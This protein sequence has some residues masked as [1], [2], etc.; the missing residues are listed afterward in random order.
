[1]PTSDHIFI[2]YARDQGPGQSLAVRLQAR[3]EAHGIPCWR[4]E[5]DT[6]V[7][8][9]WPTHIPEA[10]KHARLM[11][12][13]VSTAAHDSHWVREEITLALRRD[14]AV[15]ILPVLAESD[16]ALP[17]GLNEF[18]PLDMATGGEEAFE[19]LLQRIGNLDS[20]GA[21]PARRVEI[22]YLQNLLH[23]Q[24]LEKLA[25]VYEPL[26]G[27]QRRQATMA[28]VL[29]GDEMQ[30]DLRLLRQLFAAP[31]KEMQAPEHFE[32]VLVVLGKASRLAVLGEPGA[33]KTHALKRIAA[34]MARTALED[35]KAPLPLFVPLRE[36]IE[37]EQRLDAFLAA[38]LEGLGAGWRSLLNDKRAAVLF[39]GLNELPTADRQIKMPQIRELAHDD[40]LPVV[41]AT[42][43]VNDFEGDL[44]LDL[45]TLEILP[46]DERRIL[47]F[48]QR[49]LRALH[50][51]NGDEEGTRLFWLLAGGEW[52]ESA[53]HTAASRDV[54]FEQFWQIGGVDPPLVADD[55]WEL[56]WALERAR[57][58]KADERNLLR[59]AANP[60]LLKML[61]EVY[62][63]GGGQALPKNR[64]ALFQAFATI[65]IQR[66][67]R[68]HRQREKTPHPGRKD[69]ELA[70]GRFA[71]ELQNRAG[72]GEKVQ[73]AMPADEASAY[74]SADQLRLARDAN[75]LDVS[76]TARFSHQLMQEFF[77]A[78]GMLKK[79]AVGELPA[80]RLWP[81]G[82]WWAR[83]GWEEASVFLAGLTP[84]DPTLIV[85]W[86]RDAQP[87]VLRQCLKHSGC[88]LPNAAQLA[89]LKRRWLPR[90]DPEREPAP[91]AR[92]WVSTALGFLG[93][94]DRL[95]VGLDDI[96]LPDIDWVEI[97]AGPFRYGENKRARELP[98][99][100]IS[101]FPITNVQ[102]QV[103]VDD[104]G[105]ESKAPWWEILAEQFDSPDHPRWTESNRPRESISWFEAIA[106]C[107]WLSSVLGFEVR[108]PSEIEWEKATRGTDGR[109]YPWG[110]GY[111]AG[112][113]N[114]NETRV[115]AGPTFLGQTT[116]V[117]LYPQAASPSGVED[118][119]G[120]VWE[121]CLNEY[122][123]PDSAGLVG[124]ASRVLRGGSWDG[125]PDVARA[126]YR[127]GDGPGNRLENV[128]FRVVCASP[129]A[130]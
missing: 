102:F 21:G 26:S 54:S 120:N 74:L 113:A 20:F 9:T 79:I 93:L 66:E 36:W 94:D 27:D 105:Y 25:Q 119:V 6:E 115:D 81:A 3:L 51:Q 38:H 30:M 61:I 104:G 43:R 33:G 18:Q 55:D 5:S 90:L 31:G 22:A 124:T 99:F 100:Y 108:L 12:C 80:E 92:H 45:D 69:I 52:L 112:F 68:R 49:Y 130:R 35:D 41:V 17:Y 86:L 98:A 64:A 24:G 42:C 67:D 28:S 57:A 125:S 96:G 88:A 122:R 65:L 84:D 29:P 19:N 56:R 110:S 15:P 48:C 91:E 7:G 11:L 72:D 60:Y 40:R 116:A 73:L 14:V 127:G 10:L 83:T 50:P 34:E 101:R 1:M 118:L 121:W 53:W 97:A 114:I 58:A 103:F 59:L 87:E 109:E 70:L 39:D 62:L 13:V 32:D 16:I 77:V 117:G 89:D 63:A 82:Q 71:W 44:K 2:S 46:L 75:L 23:R 85:E 95:G 37:P 76:D 4:D 123:A 78:L 107:R 8:Q 128:G 126:L 47:R 111:R 129:I 106:Y